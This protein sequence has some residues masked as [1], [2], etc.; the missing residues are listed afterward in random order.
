LLGKVQPIVIE[1]AKVMSKAAFDQ[2]PLVIKDAIEKSHADFSKIETQA[3]EASSASHVVQDLPTL[4]D[5]GGFLNQSQDMS[6]LF[7]GVSL[8]IL[9]LVFGIVGSRVRP[10]LDW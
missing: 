7:S 1:L 6:R 5:C 10:A 3:E 4:K 8:K 2:V 9:P